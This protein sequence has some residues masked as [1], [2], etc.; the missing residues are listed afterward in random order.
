[1]WP[2]V[3]MAALSAV[4]ARQDQ[5]NYQDQSQVASATQRYSPWTHMQAQ[6]PQRPNSAAT[7][8]QGVG[9]GLAM[10]QAYDKA[11]P[12]T[13]PTTEQPGALALAPA[14]QDS[15]GVQ[16][17]DQ[18]SYADAQKAAMAKRMGS[19]NYMGS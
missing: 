14:S 9:S 19:W 4:K 18:P 17:G 15:Y 12:P 10:Q 5:T 11:N 1:M 13:T 2:L 8:T 16:P 6:A 7:L 3:A